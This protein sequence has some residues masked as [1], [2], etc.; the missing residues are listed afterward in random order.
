[1]VHDVFNLIQPYDQSLIS[2]CMSN[3]AVRTFENVKMMDV[4]H[5]FHSL[6]GRVCVCVCT[7]SS[8]CLLT[9][10]AVGLGVLSSRGSRLGDPVSVVL[11]LAAVG[12]RLCLVAERH[13]GGGSVGSGGVVFGV[14]KAVQVFAGSIYGA[15]DGTFSGSSHAV[16]LR[17]VQVVGD[18]GFYTAV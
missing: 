1:M 17:L 3:H 10:A 18:T 11:L 15:V 5:H 9:V 14:G 12:R 13:D 6:E 16:L 4:L 2:V 8:W 7:L